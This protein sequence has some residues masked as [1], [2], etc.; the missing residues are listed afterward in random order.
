MFKTRTF[1]TVEEVVDYVTTFFPSKPDNTRYDDKFIPSPSR[2]R[3]IMRDTLSKKHCGSWYFGGK[4]GFL[5]HGWYKVEVDAAVESFRRLGY[6]VEWTS[7]E[8]W[9]IDFF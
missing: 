6:K 1:K 2:V 9:K 5:K 7:I 4:K 3:W 8:E